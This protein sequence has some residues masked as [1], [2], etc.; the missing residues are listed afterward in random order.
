MVQLTQQYK[1]LQLMANNAKKPKNYRQM[2]EELD[3]ILIWFENGD[4]DLDEAIQKYE[5]ALVLLDSMED[6]LKTAQNKVRKISAS[7]SNP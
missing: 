3:N 1:G 4:V 5:Q 2:S 6:Y 7:K